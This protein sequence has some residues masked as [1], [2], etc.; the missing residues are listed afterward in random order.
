MPAPRN[1][2]S[3]PTIAALRA[4][5]GAGRR[6]VRRNH[7]GAVKV[8][9]YVRVSGEEQKATGLGVD[10]QKAAILAECDKR[11]WQV[12]AF[13]T[14]EGVSGRVPP[15]KRPGLHDAIVALD[16]G[17]A[18][19]LVVA[20]VDRLARSIA[21]LALLSQLGERAG[22]NI[23]ALNSPFDTTTPTGVAM[24]S[25]MGL[26]AQLEAAMGSE[27][28]KAV[29]AVRR[30]RG[31]QLGRPSQVSEEARARLRELREQG[32]SWPKVAAAMNAEGWPTS[33]GGKWYP[34]TAQRLAVHSGA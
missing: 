19:T 32:L 25:M 12:I 5:R 30:A 15:D 7:N 4:A 17:E 13:Y 24:A 20:K 8:V 21:D 11:G 28:M 26:F 1:T 16:D 6:R 23:V 29:A 22:W 3:S 9:G 33:Q 27:R 31:E 14:D 2:L 18:R 10:A 34:A